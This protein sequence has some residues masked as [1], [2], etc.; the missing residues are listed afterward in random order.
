MRVE[1]PRAARYVFVAPATLTD[2]E[3]SQQSQESTWDLSL[4]GCQ[5]MPG[6]SSR[7]GAR[8]RVQ[9]FHNGT[10]F[11]ALGR[12]TNVRPLMGAGIVFTKIE[13]K[14]QAVLDQWLA[15]ARNNHHK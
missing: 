4:F 12:V 15:A 13:E 5:V 11:E 14:H 1:R 9:I 7:I 2:L 10:S 6:S 8:V 3:S